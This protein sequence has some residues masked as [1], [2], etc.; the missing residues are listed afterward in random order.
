MRSWLKTTGV[1]LS[2]ALDRPL[3]SSTR[4]RSM[5][6]SSPPSACSTS[7]FRRGPSAGT[8]N[9]ATISARALPVR[10]TPDSAL[11]PK[12]SPRSSRRMDLPAPVSPVSAPKP[13]PKSSSRWS[14]ITK[15]RM[16]RWSRMG[17]SINWLRQL[18][19]KYYREV[20]LARCSSKDWMKRASLII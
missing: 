7:Q 3:L 10:M 8:S 4:I 12:A 18:G 5:T 2:H 1:P 11:L 13:A 16:V 19:M 14:T 20:E 6:S 15:S 17:S 9:S